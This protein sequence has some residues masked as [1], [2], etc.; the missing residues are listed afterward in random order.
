M[1]CTVVGRSASDSALSYSREA[2]LAVTRAATCFAAEQPVRTWWEVAPTLA[3][4]A[5]LQAALIGLRLPLVLM[6]ALAVLF[7][8]VLLRI[9]MF[10][11]DVHHHA[12]F[13]RSP[14]GRLLVNLFS[15][16]FIYSPAVWRSRHDAHH[17]HNSLAN[18]REIPGQIPMITL[19]RWR[20]LDPRAKRLYR[21]FRH[22]LAV[23]FG[24]VPYFVVPCWKAF[25]EDPRRYW[26]API[27][28][29]MPPLLLLLVAMS[30]DVQT[31]LL[32]IG[33]PVALS[34]ALGSYLFYAQHSVEGIRY[35]EREDWNYF[36]AA[37]ETSSMFEM[38][39]LMHWFTGNIG[40]HHV[41]HVHAAIPF[42]RLPEA[43]AA[44]PALQRPVRTSWHPRDI[45]FALTHHIWDD[46]TGRLLT[47][48]EADR[49]AGR[50]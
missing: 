30:T 19:S 23:T 47:Y 3:S 8:L 15:I 20:T 18:A 44:I 16:Y 4:G 1:G 7:A 11:H 25:K 24:V 13:R 34:S 48:R 33:L 41:H 10:F 5:A 2:A 21:I 39:R 14:L 50:V 26:T 32:A 49:R 6:L 35:Q 40:Y 31:S 45:R 27:W 42:Y 36:Y 29:A 12:I 9:F 22:P 37:L 28:I 38:P 46:D 17:R 43:M